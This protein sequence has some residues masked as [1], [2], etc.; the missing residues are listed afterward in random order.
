MYKEDP[1]IWNAIFEMVVAEFAYLE[2]HG[3]DLGGAGRL[4]PIV[5]GNK[6]DWSYLEPWF[7]LG[8]MPLD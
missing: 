4:F 2:E 8:C 7:Y 5:I 3:L 6:G 1:R